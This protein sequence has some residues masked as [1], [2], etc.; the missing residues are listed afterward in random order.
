MKGSIVE[1]KPRPITSPNTCRSGKVE[2]VDP[3][4]LK[5]TMAT[6]AKRNVYTVTVKESY[7]ERA[8]LPNM[9]YKA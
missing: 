4:P 9:L 5:G 2:S 6:A 1:R 7:F 3:N 8:A